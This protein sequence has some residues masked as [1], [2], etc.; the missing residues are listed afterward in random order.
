MLDNIF[1]LE[2]LRTVCHTLTLS[3]LS[4]KYLKGEKM[5]RCYVETTRRYQTL[6]DATRRYLTLPDALYIAAHEHSKL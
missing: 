6:P 1:Y 2:T 5:Q 4:A 3:E